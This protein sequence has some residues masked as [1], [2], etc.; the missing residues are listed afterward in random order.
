MIRIEDGICRIFAMASTCCKV[1]GRHSVV[2]ATVLGVCAECIKIRFDRAKR[3]IYRAHE[4]SRR[5]FKLP[6]IAP[7]DGK[8]L[9]PF[10]MHSCKID[11]NETGFCGLGLDER[12]EAVL[13]YYF[14]PLPTNCVAS[15]VCAGCAGAGYPE[16]AYSPSGDR[17]FKNLAV[18]YEACSFNCLYCQN[19]HFKY[20][21]SRKISP[22]EL[23]LAVDEFTSCV[24]FFGGDPA[25]YI[26]H[27]IATAEEALKLR[28]SR[29]LRICWETNGSMSP[30]FLEKT[31]KISLETGGCIKFDLKAFNFNLHFA[32]TGVSNERALENFK[33]VA[34]KFD[35]RPHPP[36]LVAS[37]LIV[38]GYIDSEEVFQIAKFISSINKNIPYSLLAFYPEFYLSDLPCTSL[39]HMEECYNA[40]LKAGLTNVHIGNKHLLRRKDYE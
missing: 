33:L 12:K 30:L 2:I 15:F 39:R 27:S 14:D 26:H 5:R 25:P 10:C 18:F 40:A 21:R 22:I 17:G 3:F 38:P 4:E 24:C 13:E 35:V 37:T 16:F 28:K 6:T 20:R 9:C 29:I 1:C 8:K 19:W 11:A 32:L 36:L 34:Q 31:V 7:Q 23:A